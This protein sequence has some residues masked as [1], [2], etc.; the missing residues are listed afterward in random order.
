M[1][2]RTGYC[3]EPATPRYREAGILPVSAGYLSDA[4][5]LTD[6]A[7]VFAAVLTALAVIGGLVVISTRRRAPEPA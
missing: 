6:G 1:A 4:V 3:S 2:G 7:T 5:G